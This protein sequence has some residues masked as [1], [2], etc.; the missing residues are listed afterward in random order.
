MDSLGKTVIHVLAGWIGIAGDLIT[1]LRRA[2]DLK[3]IS[4]IFHLIFL[5]L[6]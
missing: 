2:L 6:S 3:L 5:D 4:G 1:L